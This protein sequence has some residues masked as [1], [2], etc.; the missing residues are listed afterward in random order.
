MTSADVVV[1]GG[2]V[3]G[4]SVAFNLA[5]LGVRRVVL[6]ER[7]HLG[8]GASGKSGSLVR[9]HYT[10]EAESRL[11]WESLKVFRDFDAMV[12]GDCGSRHPASCRSWTP[13]TPMPS[14]PMWPCSRAW[15]STPVSSRGKSSR[16]SPPTCASTT[17]A[18][19]PTRPA[20]HSPHPTPPTLRSRRPR[21]GWGRPSRRT[22]RRFASSRR[23]AAWPAWRRPEDGWPLP[24]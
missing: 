16:R 14:G 3:N 8:A 7:R 12:G 23:G 2:G 9:M 18:P 11:A 1:I 10:N 19:P 24:W 5:R 15:V 20:P 22:A 13:P 6:L 21:A 17:W 4:A